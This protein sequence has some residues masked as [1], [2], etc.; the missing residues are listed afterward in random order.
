[1][2]QKKEMYTIGYDIG[3]SSIKAALVKAD[4]GDIIN[5]VQEPGFEMGMEADQ[6]GWAEQNPADWWS[7]VCKATQRLIDE[8]GIDPAEVKGIG[9]GYQM[10]GLVLVDEQQSIVRPAIIWCDSRAVDYGEAAFQEIGAENCLSHC[11]N[12]PGNFTAAKLKWVKENEPDNYARTAYAMLPGDYIAMRFSGHPATTVSGLSE[13]VLWDFKKQQ[14]A[15]QVLSSMGLDADKI[16]TIVPTLGLQA[17]I[18]T[19]GEAE[20]GLPAGT[21]I[22]Y[23]AG[24]QPNNALALNVLEPGEVA[25]TGG[26]S[27]VVYA[28]TD[29]LIADPQQRVNSFAHIN[30]NADQTRIGVLLCI[31]GSGILHR[32]VRNTIVGQDISYAQMEEEAT[33]API[34]ADGLSFLPFGNGAE[35]LLGNRVLGAQLLGIDLNRHE[36]PHLIRAGLEGIAFA[37]VYGMRAMQELG[38]DMSRIRVGDDNLFQSSVFAETIAA[39]TGSTIEVYRTTGAI[40]AALAATVAAEIHPDL[41]TALGKISPLRSQEPPANL[42]AYEAAYNR[43]CERLEKAMAE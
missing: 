32:W 22:G 15:Q 23:R 13:G 42:K 9:I 39:L 5:R 38:L 29:K 25:A 1:M 41:S 12:S 6:T 4:T 26:T 35:R 14:T 18:S 37:F 34:G 31:N 16:P 10:H 27:G 21:P 17:V 36:R 8:T 24:D 3:S 2:K 43:W 7:Y 19:S 11:L 30:H 33:K 28:V 40:G 20:T